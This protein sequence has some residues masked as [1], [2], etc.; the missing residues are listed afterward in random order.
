MELGETVGRLGIDRDVDY[1][2]DLVRD[3]SDPRTASFSDIVSLCLVPYLSL[4][5]HESYQKLK[6]SDPVMA[7]S[8]SSEVKSI[9]SRSRQSLKLFEDKD[10]GIDGQFKYFRNKVLPASTKRFL[11]NTW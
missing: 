1:V 9:V 6:H 2:G 3:L 11:G 10:R 4:M 5:V 7:E 8:L